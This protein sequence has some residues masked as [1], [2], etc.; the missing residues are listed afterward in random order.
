MVWLLVKA[1]PF[2]KLRP[3]PGIWFPNVLNFAL[4]LSLNS[5]RLFFLSLFT[6]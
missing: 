3:K 1:G 2:A 6:C 4:V 5:H